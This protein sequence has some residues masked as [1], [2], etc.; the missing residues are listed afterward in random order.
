[1]IVADEAGRRGGVVVVVRVWHGGRSGDIRRV[2]VVQ[3]CAPGSGYMTERPL[4]AAAI[5]DMAI[6]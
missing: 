1:M 6:I 4:C 2:L 3:S 5:R